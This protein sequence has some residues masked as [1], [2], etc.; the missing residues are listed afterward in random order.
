MGKSDGYCDAGTTAGA[1]KVVVEFTL[2]LT[3]SL[4]KTNTAKT[5]ARKRIV[6]GL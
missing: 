3:F 1:D 5:T 4:A 2:N 6:A